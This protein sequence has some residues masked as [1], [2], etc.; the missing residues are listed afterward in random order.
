M[1]DSTPS[2]T[3]AGAKSR[4]AVVLAN[5]RPP[6]AHFALLRGSRRADRRE[7]C[8]RNV[9]IVYRRMRGLFQFFLL[10]SFAVAGSISGTV[11]WRINGTSKPCARAEIVVRSASNS[12]VTQSSVTDEEGHYSIPEIAGRFS[13][14]VSRPG[15]LPRTIARHGRELVIDLERDERIDNA[16][17]EVIPGGVIMGRITDPQGTPMDGVV[18]IVS[19]RTPRYP[20]P[21]RIAKT[22][23]RGIY[24]VFG[25]E[26]GQYLVFARPSHWAGAGRPTEIYYREAS[27]RER[28]DLVQAVAGRE[29][30]GIDL[31]LR[32][33]P[34]FRVA[35]KVVGLNPDELSRLRIV[36]AT[37]PDP[38]Q[39]S[40]SY[41]TPVERDGSFVFDLPAGAY[42][43]MAPR[44]GGL[45]MIRRRLEVAA[46]IT[47]LLLQPARPGRLSGRLFF[48]AAEDR[49]M[50][51]E[52]SL[53]AVD[54]TGL[55]DLQMVARSPEYRFDSGE[56][57]AGTYTLRLA[58]PADG[59]IM[60]VTEGSRRSGEDVMVAEGGETAVQ[61]EVARDLV[62]V[63][64][65]AKIRSG[66]PL[67]Q[68]TV[69]LTGTVAPSLEVQVVQADQRG[70]FI[71]PAVR[72]GE[73]VVCVL[74][75]QT[76]A[77]S[78]ISQK[79]QNEGTGVMHLRVG[80]SATV[81]SDV[82]VTSAAGI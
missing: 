45:T 38:P 24:R 50:P 22:N 14:S 3:S 23:D 21:F 59:H 67:P 58:S 10:T 4:A 57:T 70:R 12:Q 33:A 35:G 27:Y 2:P 42:S 51:H 31:V 44:P 47:G 28:A 7:T 68:A 15:Y 37:A 52:V 77:A 6:A 18:V 26:P 49:P 69:A 62:Q 19:S 55:P 17:F 66:A 48:R 74:P 61:I 75:R 81:E 16:D 39:S 20:E 25:L 53:R 65:V 64:G 40:V 56:I 5:E 72:P 82:I 80:G 29:T 8:R 71:F 79:C 32:P 36:A 54:K 60:K 43:V 76:D 9:I 11:Y 1:P 46:N 63:R 73:Y 78:G 30:G 34:V 41:S 13:V